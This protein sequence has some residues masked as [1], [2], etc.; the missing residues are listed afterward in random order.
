MFGVLF[1]QFKEIET[2]KE[3]LMASNRSLAEFNLAR[4]PHLISGKQRIQELSEEGERI[5]NSVEA[6]SKEFCK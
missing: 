5:Y 3:M 6:K 4:E 2:E 1:K